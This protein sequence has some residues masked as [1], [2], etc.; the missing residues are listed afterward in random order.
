MAVILAF[1]PLLSR[2]LTATRP[3]G[4]DQEPEGQILFFTGVRYER[5]AEAARDDAGPSATPTTGG[6]RGAPPQ[7]RRRRG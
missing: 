2:R 4:A 1:T 5:H 6:G 3:P 7:K